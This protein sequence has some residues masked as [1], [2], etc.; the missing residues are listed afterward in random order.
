MQPDLGITH[1]PF[2]LGDWHEGRDR[3]DDDD[4]DGATPRQLL[5]DLKRLLSGVR[6][7]QEEMI[8]IDAQCAG[9]RGVER[10]LGVDERCDPIA[11]LHLSDHV[12]RDRRLP[13]R[14]GAE[15]L[16]DPAARH[17]A[18]AECDV[19]CERPGRHG[20]HFE[21]LRTVAEPHDGPFSIGL[22]DLLECVLQYLA[23]TH[24]SCPLHLDYPTF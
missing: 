3:V 14:L 5:G 16:N 18:D 7:R 17:P 13:A 9:V 22:L 21:D 11:P 23:L 20:L 12:K 24:S 1:L 4:V 6:L 15:D 10:V 19:Q 2:N 8:E